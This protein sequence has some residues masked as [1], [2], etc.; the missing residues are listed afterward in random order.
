L[1]SDAIFQAWNK[2][3]KEAVKWVEDELSR[4]LIATNAILEGLRARVKDR[5]FAWSPKFRFPG[6]LDFKNPELSRLAFVVRYESFMGAVDIREKRTRPWGERVREGL[7]IPL[8][9]MGGEPCFFRIPD[10][11][12]CPVVL[13]G[14]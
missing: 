8:K 13:I 4:R 3:R 11:P 10:S 7:S 14:S 1:K 9:K 2:G 5:L 12:L 6:A